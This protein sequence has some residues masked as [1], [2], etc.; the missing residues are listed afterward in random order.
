[1]AFLSISA[2]YLGNLEHQ[3]GIA[4]VGS[5]TGGLPGM[6][7]SWWFPMDGFPRLAATA[8]VISFVSLLESISIA[9]ALAEPQ[10]DVLHPLNPNQELLGGQRADQPRPSPS[11]LGRHTGL[12]RGQELLS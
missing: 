4:I 11:E 6:T 10:Q 3:A 12:R 8:V 1:M 5:I 2:V 9:R 7:T